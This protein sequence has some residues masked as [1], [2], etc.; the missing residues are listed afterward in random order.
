MRGSGRQEGSQKDFGRVG[1]KSF[2]RILE[3]SGGFG[4]NSRRIIAGE[5]RVLV[6]YTRVL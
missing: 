5:G 6:E 1:G 4:K 2:E 3:E